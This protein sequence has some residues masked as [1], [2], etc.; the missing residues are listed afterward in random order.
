MTALTRTLRAHALRFPETREDFPWEDDRVIKV[1]KK[2]F[3]FLGDRSI[4]VKLTH[5]NQA[6]LGLP[7]VTPMAYGLG[8]SGWVTVDLSKSR[9]PAID[10]LKAWI[11]ESYRAVAPKTLV[12]R[13]T[14]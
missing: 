2:I 4:G 9:K 7:F 12:A 8:R 13:L 6:A 3:V 11:D 5:S 10:L 1:K 14:S